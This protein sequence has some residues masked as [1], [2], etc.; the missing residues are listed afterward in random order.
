[1]QKIDTFN[2][3]VYD[4]GLGFFLQLPNYFFVAL[5]QKKNIGTI[6]QNA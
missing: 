3:D 1:L 5:R 6:K 2:C 4:G